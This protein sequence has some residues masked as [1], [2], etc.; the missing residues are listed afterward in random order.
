MK[1]GK[2]LSSVLISAAA[3]AALGILFAP[4]KGSKTRKRIRRQSN[5]FK[6]KLNSIVDN[7]VE[8]YEDVL[9]KS[10]KVKKAFS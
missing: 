7:A 6:E 9:V 10:E 2:F 3:G 5:D 1:A 4:D 8:K